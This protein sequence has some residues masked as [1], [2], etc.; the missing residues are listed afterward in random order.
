M[1][2]TR[3]DRLL[4]NLGYIES[5]AG[6]KAFL[7]DND[8]LHDGV[9]VKGVSEAVVPEKV[10]VN[11][12]PLDV[13]PGFII[14]MHKPAGYECTHAPTGGKIVYDL[15]PPRFLLRK[16]QV[17]S[18]GRLDKDTTGLLLFTD[19]GQMV[20]RL[21]GPRHHVQK[22]YEVSLRDALKGHEKELFSSGAVMLS[23][24]D[25]PLRPA[26]MEVLGEKQ[27]RLTIV[28]GRYH[29]VKRMF[30]AAENE[31]VSLH[32]CA[33]GNL[34][35]GDLSSGEWRYLTAEEMASL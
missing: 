21:A 6:A 16:P 15:L 9:R 35:L 13:L 18:I 10:T 33:F 32:R 24:E 20:Q 25:K 14:M 11:G 4:G 31:V 22:V 17:V 27:A 19:D 23:G 28:E 34:T 7:A 30:E 26:Q 8:V 1:S 12:A 5:R 3:I 2:K 29:Q